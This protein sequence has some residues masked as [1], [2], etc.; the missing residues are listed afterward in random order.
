MIKAAMTRAVL[1]MT[2]VATVPVATVAQ[3]EPATPEGT[4]WHLA[5]YV[6]DGAMM[7]LPWFVDATLMLSD[8]TATGSGGCNGFTGSYE[9][10]GDSL[11][12]DE[13]FAATRKACPEPQSSVETDYLAILPLVAGWSLEDDGLQLTD[14]EG[15]VILEFEQAVSALT[16]SDIAAIAAQFEAQAAALD[17]LE[18]RVGNI[19]L[20]TLR[21]R[22]KQLE[23]QVKQLRASRASSSRGSGSTSGSFSAA[24]KTLIKGIPA[25]IRTTCSPLRGNDLPNGTVA[26]V[27]C[28]PK[29]KLV[30]E[31]A[32]YL[33]EYPNALA[34][35]RSVM[36]ANNVTRGY[37]CSSGKPGFTGT[38]SSSPPFQA[39]GCF[40]RNGKAN[41]RVLDAAAECRQL[42]V[43]GT[44]LRKP[45]LYVAIEGTT[46][47][48]G[49]LA[50]WTRIPDEDPYVLY[51]VTRTISQGNRPNSGCR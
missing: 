19:R 23:G 5:S 51:D 30:D 44:Q 11:D 32:Y 24:E 26:A 42:K 48:I 12:F 37:S 43:A 9:L 20:G 2:L 8:G 25:N 17:R 31:M 39:E 21:D 47:R 46:K 1:A 7:A 22:I 3:G 50:R 4:E 14:A 28:Q 13:A 38:M 16:A 29:T 41:M 6:A 36:Q 34:T 10:S 45:T 40:V 27:Q 35:M 18:Q 49:P 33:M 15:S